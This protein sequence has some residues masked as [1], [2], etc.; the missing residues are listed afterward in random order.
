[1][2][3][4]TPNTDPRK[5]RPMTEESGKGGAETNETTA[6]VK[7]LEDIENEVSERLKNISGFLEVMKNYI[8][9]LGFIDAHTQAIK[10]STD[11]IKKVCL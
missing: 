10:L 11:Q 9:K 8:P 2:A 5:G 1:M 7:G 4:P 6:A 3:L